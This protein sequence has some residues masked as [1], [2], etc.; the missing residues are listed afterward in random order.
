M[1][2][3]LAMNLNRPKA[4]VGLKT[5]VALTT[6][7]WVPL[8]VL[9]AML[10]YMLHEQI[11]A[12]SVE[13]IK[14]HL[15]GSKEVY[16]ERGKLIGNLLAHVS[17]APDTQKAFSDR[18]APKLQNLLID[19][20]K[21][22][23]SAQIWIA[24]DENQ[25]VIGRRNGRTG[26][27]IRIGD[28]I[29]KAL[30]TGQIT[31]S[32]ELVSRDFLAT[33]DEELAK[34]VKDTGIVQFV[35]SPVRGK[36]GVSGAIIS[37]IVI[38]GD[39]WLGNAIHNK[40]GAEMAIFAGEPPESSFLH[41]TASLPRNTW[42]IGQHF[43]KELKDNVLHGKPYFG[44]VKVGENEHMAAF[45][46]IVDSQ[47]RAIGA[48][49]V[50]IPAND[51][52]DAVYGILW[53]GSAV[54]SLIGLILAAIIVT[55]T[56]LD[57][58]RPIK[59][60]VGAMEGFGKGDLDVTLDLKT[61]DEFE[62]LGDGFNIM[63][64][65]IRKREER[66]SKHY[67]VAKLLMSTLNLTELV[68]KMLKL[69]LDV[70]DSELGVLY[71][72]EE[73][74]A[75]EVLV[76]HVYYGTKSELPTLK[77]GEGHPGRAALDRKAIILDSPKNLS[78]NEVLELGFAQA[79][80]NQIANLP[81][82]Y[83]DKV[84]G[85][86]VL[87]T[88]K[89]YSEEDRHIFEYLSSQMAISL[90]N[91]IMHQKIQ[92][93]SITDPLTRLYNRRYLNTRLEEEW[94]RSVRNNQPMSFLLSD[95]DNFKKVND[96]YGHDK[97]DEVLRGIADIIRK[98]IRKEDVGARFGGEEFVIILPNTTS[99]SALILAERIR[100][101]SESKV[102]E[103]MGRPVTLSIGIATFPE[104]NL[105]SFDEL[106]HAADQAMYK[107]KVGGKNMVIISDGTIS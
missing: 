65:G 12:D 71:L 44:I 40:F 69:V 87:G 27:F 3:M 13:S 7:F 83:K 94:S 48:F 54:A 107:A 51:M 93:L 29:Y 77:M 96:N 92:E 101:D 102:Y 5:W 4:G 63:A 68:E 86:L 21:K 61:G 23:P 9:I 31:Y 67:E 99:Q 18:S 91:A 33:E 28:A 49:G 45:E 78:S 19:M 35:I 98:N 47:N 76:P 82:I 104:L 64:N 105:K 42:I 8:T 37:G 24:V 26:D 95:A 22:N 57:V 17:S 60:L 53:K 15:K 100:N 30:T 34:R 41:A 80:P 39:A 14:I 10:F 52:H 70:T 66:L 56:Y 50:S 59:F 79:L 88:V 6:I 84:L 58:I 72:C 97:G 75:G 25:R 46:Q 89:Q 43:P 81:L 73:G 55:F 103:W 32:T 85:V 38:S 11:H 20:E 36:S 90:D 1:G 62:K 2:K 74:D 106:V 16:G